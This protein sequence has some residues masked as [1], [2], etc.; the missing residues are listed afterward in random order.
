MQD[1]QSES[2]VSQNCYGQAMPVV[3]QFPL[4][5]YVQRISAQKVV[6]YIVISPQRFPSESSL[7]LK[8]QRKGHN[9]TDVR[10]RSG[11]R[12]DTPLCF[13][14]QAWEAN[15]GGK[16]GRQIWEAIQ[17]GNSGRQFWEAIRGANSGKPLDRGIPGRTC[18]AI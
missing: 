5:S 17:G 15:M 1:L 18:I 10:P 9:F 16:S 2:N 4:S 12:S 6:G 14:L 11:K 8:P 13:D 7:R 3:L